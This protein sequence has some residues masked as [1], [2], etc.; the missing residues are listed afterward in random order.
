V[1]YREVNSWRSAPIG[2][3][4]DTGVS[5]IFHRMHDGSWAHESVMDVEPYV[6]ANKEARA[7]L[8]PRT[9][10]QH[11]KGMLVARIPPIFFEKWLTDHGVDYFNPDHQA[12]IDA[13]LDGDYAWMKTTDMQL[14]KRQVSKALIERRLAMRKMFEAD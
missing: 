5:K 9:D 4:P 14:A 6:E 3:N 8:D 2:Y 12:K 13:M 11:D 10:D 1:S 7:H